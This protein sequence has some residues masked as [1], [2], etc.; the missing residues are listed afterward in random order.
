MAAI[1]V[2]IQP[3]G[4]SDYTKEPEED[5]TATI[6]NNDCVTG[7]S[8]YGLDDDSVNENDT[9]A[10]AASSITP[11]NEMEATPLNEMEDTSVD[12]CRQLFGGLNNLGNTCYLNSALQMVASLDEF[13]RQIKQCA[14]EEEDSKLR[15]ALIAVLDKLAEGETLRPDEFKNRVDERSPLFVGY[16]QQ[17][18]HEFL[19]TLLDLIDEDYKNKGKVDQEIDNAGG[20]DSNEEKEE[21]DDEPQNDE[22]ESSPV[23]KQRLEDSLEDSSEENGFVLVPSPPKSPPTTQSFKELQFADI[24]Y[25]LHGDKSGSK[26]S[27]DKVERQEGPKCKLVGGRMNTSGVILTPF[28][29]TCPTG[30]ETSKE[31]KNEVQDESDSENQKA[32]SPVDSYFT[33]EVR[34]CLTCDSCKYRRSHTETYLHLSLEIGQN[35]SSLEDGL[36][37]FFAPEKREIKCEKCFCETAMQTSEITK[38]PRAMLFHLKRFIVD[39]SPDWSSISYRKDQSPVSYEEDLSFDEDGV[40]SDFL[41]ADVSLPS[42]STAYSIRSVVNHIGSS[43]SCGHYTADAKRKNK[44]ERKWL[45][46]NDSVVSEISSTN[47]VE[48]SS[49]TA[50]MIMYE[51]DS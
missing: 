44:G 42:S 11:L 43:A 34:V 12:L 23:K 22:P 2:S 49:Q 9:D 20:A 37:K 40:L 6:S 46:F 28:D 29:G 27:N 7:R 47:A 35:C 18:S 30:E 15:E 25:L 16:L 5:V 21:A 50:Y 48:N 1:V 51:I 24:E 19:T 8:R 13:H 10:S 33:T 26:Q 45:R 31:T 38:L 4:F 32:C 41:A 3:H 39:V 17:D 14:P 36:R